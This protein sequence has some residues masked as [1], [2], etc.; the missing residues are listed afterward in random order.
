MITHGY[1]LVSDNSGSGN[2]NNRREQRDGSGNNSSRQEDSLTDDEEVRVA[3]NSRHSTPHPS[4]GTSI[5]KE[6][7]SISM[8]YR[9][10]TDM[11]IRC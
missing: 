7:P 1:Y 6:N 8:P 10:L 9:R 2:R 11:R 5:I 4:P 3:E